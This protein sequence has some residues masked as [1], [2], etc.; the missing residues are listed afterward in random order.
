MRKGGVNKPV[1]SI[2]KYTCHKP[3]SA[4]VQMEVPIFPQYRPSAPLNYAYKKK[5]TA[6]IATDVMVGKS[7]Q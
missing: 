2:L 3:G 4:V 6:G 1:S 5:C 7:E